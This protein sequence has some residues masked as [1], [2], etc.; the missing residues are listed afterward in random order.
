MNKLLQ[1]L[2]IINRLSSYQRREFNGDLLAGIIVA[3]MLIPQAMAYAMLA[4]LPPEIGLYASILPLVIYSLFGS[5]NFLSVGPV[6]ITSLMVASTIA[7]TS[8]GGFTGGAIVVGL[9]LALISGLIL[10]MMGLARLGF[11][12]NFISHPVIIGFI[13]AAAILIALS[14]LKHVLGIAIPYDVS[15]LGILPYAIRNSDLISFI[16]VAIGLSAVALLVL[17]NKPLEKLLLSTGV[18]N[19]VAAIVCKLGPIVVIVLGALTVKFFEL[20]QTHSVAITGDIPSGLP[21]FNLS[22]FDFSIIK[23]LIVPALIISLV[24]FVE[25]VSVAKSLASKRR[26]KVE[27]NQELVALGLANISASVTGACPV[28]GGFSRSA[29]NYS[30]GANSGLASIITAIF[31]AISLVFFTPWF[32]YLPKAVLAATII[33]AIINLIDVKGFVE[34]WR[35]NKA[36]SASL[37][38]TFFTVIALGI[39]LGIVAGIIVSISLYLLRTSMPHIAIV[40]RVGAS[41]HFRNVKHYD[42]TVYHDTLIIRVDESLYFANSRYLEDQLLIAVAEQKQLKNIILICS[43][44]NF[45][46]SSAVEAL[47]NLIAELRDSDVTFHLAEVKIPVLRQ[48]Q[49]SDLL[50][51][52]PPGKVFMSTHD[53][54]QELCE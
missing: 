32:Y 17:A 40:G 31:I 49:R 7:E 45:I 42:V 39:E 38:I 47:H 25:S 52:L 27:P 51:Q 41:E 9:M 18:N 15:T 26:Q 6:A 16:T 24:G 23:Q 43:A 44:I 1:F 19:K 5:S 12:V 22:L 8:A 54:V 11:L 53:A 28:T 48:L 13:S 36:D 50:Q 3:I 10:L 29:V 37:I 21:N 30:A 46:D 35:Y 33:V 20:D 2:P 14:Q 4:G 34:T